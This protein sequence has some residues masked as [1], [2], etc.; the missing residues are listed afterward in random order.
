MMTSMGDRVKSFLPERIDFVRC[1]KK[2]GLDSEIGSC[3]SDRA[4]ACPTSMHV[5]Y[6]LKYFPL[7]NSIGNK[8]RIANY[9]V[10]EKSF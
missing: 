8:K 1:A 9:I 6:F 5:P 10:E 4:R 2:E 7:E 3:I